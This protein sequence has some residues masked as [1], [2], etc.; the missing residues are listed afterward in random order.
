MAHIEQKGKQWIIIIVT[1]ISR[2]TDRCLRNSQH[3]QSTTK[4]RQKERKKASTRFLSYLIERN[5]PYKN[6]PQDVVGTNF[7]IHPSDLQ[8]KF[9]RNYRRGSRIHGPPHGIPHKRRRYLGSRP[10][11][12]T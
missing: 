11:S 3:G 1:S 6:Q 9:G 10:K 7:G 2:R 5:R 8:P 12:Q 4:R